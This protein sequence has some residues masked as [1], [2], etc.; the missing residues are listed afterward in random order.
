MTLNELIRWHAKKAKAVTGGKGDFH[1]EAAKLL[2]GLANAEA[3][4]RQGSRT[5]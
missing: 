1:A 3:D 5:E 4:R 2:R